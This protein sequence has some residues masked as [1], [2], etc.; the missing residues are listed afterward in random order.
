MSYISVVTI[1]VGLLMMLSAYAVQAAEPQSLN[2]TRTTP[3]GG[4]V[5]RSGTLDDG[6]YVGSTSRTGASG[7]SYNSSITCEGG[8]VANCSR[9]F[10][11]TNRDGQAY[12]GTRESA[13]GPRRAGATT[14]VTGPDGNTRERTRIRR[15]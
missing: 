9:S 7:G 4:Q 14:T 15:R 3:A 5:S 8:V 13:A 1:T 12:T 11:G 10:S 6:T 2:V